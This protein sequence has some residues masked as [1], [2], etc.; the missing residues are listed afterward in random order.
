MYCTYYINIGTSRSHKKNWMPF[1]HHLVF[2]NSKLTDACNYLLQEL[3]IDN[4]C[5]FNFLI[6]KL[7][8]ATFM[9]YSRPNPAHFRPLLFSFDWE[10]SWKNPALLE[11]R[12]YSWCIST[13]PPLQRFYL[14]YVPAVIQLPSGMSYKPINLRTSFSTNPRCIPDELFYFPLQ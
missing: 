2:V 5:N 9:P 11:Q 14:R 4:L 7:A 8:L 3:Q 13:Q 12:A 6:L 10:W 1:W